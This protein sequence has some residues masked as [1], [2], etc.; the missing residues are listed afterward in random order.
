[1][2]SQTKNTSDRFESKKYNDERE[3]FIN[4]LF[5]H[6]LSKFSLSRVRCFSLT[7]FVL[8]SRED[9]ILRILLIFHE[10]FVY[11]AAHDLNFKLIKL[12][13]SFIFLF[14]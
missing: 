7:E 4:G 14:I 9:Q 6:A 3:N 10:N 8:L 13:S 11:S 1:M 12:Y 5:S 2:T